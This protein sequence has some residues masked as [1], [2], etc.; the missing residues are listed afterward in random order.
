MNNELHF[1]R[2]LARE[3]RRPGWRRMLDEMSSTELSEWADFFRENSFSDA[4]LDAEFST[5]KAQVFMLVTGKEI[6]AADFSL[7]TLPGAVQS[8]T[9]QDLLEVA[10]GIPGG[11][12][13]EPESR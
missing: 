6:D 8:M 11:V 4:L 13:F 3:F 7:L 12:R 1:V 5:L 9:E 10:V 2:Q